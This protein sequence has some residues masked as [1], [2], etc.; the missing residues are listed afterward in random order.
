MNRNDTTSPQFDIL[1]WIRQRQ[2][3]GEPLAAIARD[4]AVQPSTVT[5]WLSG[6]NRPTRMAR[7]FA[8]LLA[9][10]G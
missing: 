2:S 1:Y 6:A 7:A 10:R 4:L 3:A 5:M 9:Q 8:A